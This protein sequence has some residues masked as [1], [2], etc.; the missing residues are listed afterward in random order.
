MARDFSPEEIFE[1]AD[2]MFAKTRQE[3]VRD[4]CFYISNEFPNA[5]GKPN[6]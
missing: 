3:E 4:F 5:I 1:F 6:C 2:Y